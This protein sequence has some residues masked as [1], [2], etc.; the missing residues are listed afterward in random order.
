MPAHQVRLVRLHV[1]GVRADERLGRIVQQFH[2]ELVDHAA[3]DLVLHGEDVVEL[4]VVPFRPELV[5]AGGVDELCG[6]TEARAGGA[7]AALE[8]GGDTELA[9]DFADVT[10]V[11]LELEGQSARGNPHALERGE[12]GDQLLGHAL[13]EVV[14]VLARAEVAERQHGNRR[15]QLRRRCRRQGHRGEG[16]RR[17]DAQEVG[18][19]A[20][21][22]RVAVVALARQRA[23][24]HHLEHR[25]HVG[26][27]GNRQSHAR[28]RD[29]ARKGQEA[30]AVE[31]WMAGE[32]LVEHDAERPDVGAVVERV[33]VHL[34][35]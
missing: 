18:E 23:A 4:A 20:G 35:R 28:Q 13:A 15:Q 2:P 26:A 25:R 22:R 21:D 9:T 30:V 27:A 19:Q 14:L 10:R 7:H 8:H 3:R 24:D 29:A 17:G 5:A 6:D 1:L 34:F 33:T 11:P 31:R 12:R 32:H 16:R